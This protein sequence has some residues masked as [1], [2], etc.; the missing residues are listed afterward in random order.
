ML[1]T[2][3]SS[4]PY[5]TSWVVNAPTT[6]WHVSERNTQLTYPRN[7]SAILLFCWDRDSN[8]RPCDYHTV[9]V[10]TALQVCTTF[11]CWKPIIAN[12]PCW[13]PLP[14]CCKCLCSCMPI[15]S[16]MSGRP[17]WKQVGYATILFGFCKNKLVKKFWTLWNWTFE[18]ISFCIKYNFWV[19]IYC[20]ST[21]FAALLFTCMCLSLISLSSSII[22]WE[23]LDRCGIFTFLLRHIF[24]F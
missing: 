12:L 4:I 14:C 7:T 23:R 6:I 20:N 17:G 13:H 10:T 3:V 24:R 21:S 19:M 1:A 18:K 11:C 9:A 16:L 22:I 2:D 5:F 8:S 15:F